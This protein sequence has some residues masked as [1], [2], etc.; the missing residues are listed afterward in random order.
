LA[1]VKMAVLIDV[2]QFL[3][4]R[5]FV[6]SGTLLPY[7]KWLQRLEVCA[8]RW[9]DSPEAFSLAWLP[10]RRFD[11][12]RKGDVP[13]P[14]VSGDGIPWRPEAM[15]PLF[16][17]RE[18]PNEIVKSSPQVV[19]DI[20]D[21]GPQFSRRGPAIDLPDDIELEEIVKA[22]GRWQTGIWW[23]LTT[24]EVLRHSIELPNMYVR[25][26]EPLDASV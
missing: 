3:K 24:N 2:P 23:R 18:L 10:R 12:D 8:Q 6:P 5:E 21:D 25:P 16:L 4:H 11:H 19:D 9:P 17:N 13:P 7:L 22:L 26:I 15:S 1:E 20:S 14:V